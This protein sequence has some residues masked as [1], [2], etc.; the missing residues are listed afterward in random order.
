MF[1]RCKKSRSG[2]AREAVEMKRC[3]TGIDP[4]LAVPIIEANPNE[5]L[6]QVRAKA[7]ERT[8]MAAKAT[9]GEV[10]GRG[11]P[12]NGQ[13]AHLSQAER[14][15]KA[16]ISHRQQKKLDALARHAPSLFKQVQVGKKKVD[17]AYKAVA[18]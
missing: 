1:P 12:I 2:G 11:R 15:A 14:A 18:G 13:I 7:S 10:L 9:T 8:H 4:E 16:G 6:G 5:I 17:A 3:G